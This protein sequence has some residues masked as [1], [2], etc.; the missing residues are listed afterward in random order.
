MSKMV[1]MDAMIPLIKEKLNEDGKVIFTP[2][3]TSM[4]PTIVGEVDTVSLVKPKF[5][6][7]KYSI[8][9]YRRDDGSFVLHRVIG[10]KNGCYVMRGDNQFVKEKGIREDQIVGV[11]QTYVHD[12]EAHLAYGPDNYTYAKKLNRKIGRKRIYL[13]IRRRLGKIKRKI[14]RK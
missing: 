1:S 13:G 7:A 8:P 11:V 5:P 12:G 2:K 9:L 6:L 3:G 10:R 4:L 14:L